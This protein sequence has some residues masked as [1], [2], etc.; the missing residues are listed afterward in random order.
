MRALIWTHN[1]KDVWGW[2]AD[3]NTAAVYVIRSLGHVPSG[4]TLDESTS[5]L[6]WGW[7]GGSRQKDH[8]LA[9]VQSVPRLLTRIVSCPHRITCCVPQGKVFFFFHLINLLSTKLVWSRWLDIGLD[10][11]WVFM[12]LDSNS[13]QKHAKK[14]LTNIQPSLTHTWSTHIIIDQIFSL[15][16]NWSKHITWLNISQ[17]K[18]GNI[19]E[20]S[21]I[22]KT[23][24]VARKIWTIINTIASIWSKTML[25]YLS[26]DNICSL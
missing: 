24:H 7:G 13:N 20:Y 16:R 23:V 11:F 19:R 25:G 17:L 2:S 15:T 21:P 1:M 26:L 3:G 10:F 12:N 18:L 14:N 22:F 8:M 5:T 9:K 4:S 6:C